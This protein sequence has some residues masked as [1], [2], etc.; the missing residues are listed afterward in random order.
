MSPHHCGRRNVMTIPLSLTEILTKLLT[1]TVEGNTSTLGRS[2][3]FREWCSL[4]PEEKFFGSIGSFLET[5]LSGKNTFLLFTKKDELDVNLPKIFSLNKSKKPTRV[6]TIAPSDHLKFIRDRSFLEIARVRT[7]FPL[8]YAEIP[9]ATEV[10]ENCDFSLFLSLNRES[11]LIDPIDW[12]QLKHELSEWAHEAKVKLEISIATDNLFSERT[13]RTHKARSSSKQEARNRSLYHFFD[14]HQTQNNE[15]EHLLHQGIPFD[16]AGKI[17]SVNNHNADLSLIGILPNKLRSLLKLNNQD[18]YDQAFEDISKTLFWQGYSLWNKRKHLVSNFWKNI[19]PEDWKPHQK[20][21]RHAKKRLEAIIA[22]GCNN[23]FHYLTKYTDLSKQRPTPC[24]CSRVQNC[25][26]IHR[27]LNLA[28]YF[29]CISNA[30]PIISRED[31]I[32]GAHDLGK[33][34][35]DES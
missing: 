2:P 26:P 32:R 10:F 25:T 31:L 22:S 5:D 35:T 24:H 7:G 30:R 9:Q 4:F 17:N 21:H 33:C 12:D 27:F 14:P 15:L 20:Q 28:K 11:L 18:N 8:K 3:L 1:L 29:S 23:P 34:N 16:I 19:A 6:L 13:L